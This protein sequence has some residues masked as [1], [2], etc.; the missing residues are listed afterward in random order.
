MFK[1]CPNKRKPAINVR[2]GLLFSE[3]A[4]PKIIN[5]PIHALSKITQR[6]LTVSSHS[7]ELEIANHATTDNN[8]ET[9]FTIQINGRDASACH[10]DRARRE[11]E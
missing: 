6:R 9:A 10:Q 8:K 7:K 2:N 11:S 1:H 4:K 5:T 3:L